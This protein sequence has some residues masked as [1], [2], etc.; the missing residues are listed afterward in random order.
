MASGAFDVGARSAG[1]NVTLPS[2]PKPNP[3]ITPDLAFRFHYFAIRKLHF[4][5]QA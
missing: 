5:M 3:L 4:L 1:L 2:E